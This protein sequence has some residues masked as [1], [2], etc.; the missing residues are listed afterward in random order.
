MAGVWAVAVAGGG[1]DPLL[2]LAEVARRL[3]ENGILDLLRVVA[4][5]YDD[6]VERLS[7]GGAAVAGAIGS[8][9]LEGVGEA[10]GSVY[11]AAGEARVLGRCLVEALAS[12][13]G[14]APRVTGP[15][16][17]LRALQDPEV[18]RG[19]SLLLGVAKVLGRCMGEG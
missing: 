7:T 6:I 13:R 8:A 19:L 18:A 4:E 15:V 5:N 12:A 16:S 10:E 9:F 14:A 2:E 1:A 17:L 11:R 3:K